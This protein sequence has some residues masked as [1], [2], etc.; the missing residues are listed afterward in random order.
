MSVRLTVVDE[1][2]DGLRAFRPRHDLEVLV[3]ASGVLR[4][5]EQ[6]RT[7]VHG[8]GLQ[9]P[10]VRVEPVDGALDGVRR[11]AQQCRRHAHGREVVHHV[12]S[13]ERAAHRAL[14][15]RLRR[16]APRPVQRK[17]QAVFAHVHVRRLE[18]QGR[19]GETA[20]RTAVVSQLAVLAE[21]VLEHRRAPLAHLRVGHRV[22]LKA[23]VLGHPE[24]HR[25]RPGALRQLL[26]ALGDGGAQRVVRV[27][28]E[29]GPGGRAERLDDAV[30]DAVDLA[31]PVQLVAEQVQQQDVVRLQLRQGADQPELVAFE[32]A[33]IARAS[34][35]QG[36]RH[37][38]IEVRAGAIAHH[39]MAGRLHRV[40]QQV[41]D[42]GLAVRPDHHDR[43][44]AQLAPQIGD[45]ARVD[46]EGDLAREVRRR[47]AEHAL[48]RHGA[49]RAH[50]LR[51]DLSKT[52]GG[53]LSKRGTFAASM[54]S[55]YS[56]LPAP[57]RF[58]PRKRKR[59]TAP[60]AV[61]RAAS[62]ESAGSARCVRTF[63]VE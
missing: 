32:H 39:R 29:H 45:D 48:E 6:R 23:H 4:Q 50:G 19:A 58:M 56:A 61:P 10:V 34:V 57:R 33:P 14:R 53:F 49:E 8:H 35:Q 42:R 44:A 18:V 36:R 63:Q 54:V 30:L 16:R 51:A 13:R 9:A 46:V 5:V 28:D 27:V 31:A 59:S 26:G 3:E 7:A 38:G 41:A 20:V 15:R 22:L 40:R 62:T 12:G 11:A 2:R 37:A 25:R 17:R 21:R 47:T 1:E 24:G 43:T 60:P 52:H 55:K